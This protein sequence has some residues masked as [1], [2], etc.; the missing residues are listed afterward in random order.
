MV[1]GL[2]TVEDG[3][4]VSG[5]ANEAWDHGYLGVA[6]KDMKVEADLHLDNLR[7]MEC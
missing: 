1:T 2:L 7:T 3:Y 4:D 6:R 5:P